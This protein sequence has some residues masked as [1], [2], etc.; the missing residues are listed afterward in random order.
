MR[1]R[2]FD[3]YLTGFD[4]ALLRWNILAYGRGVRSRFP[5]PGSRADARPSSSCYRKVSRGDVADN[6]K[7]A[8]VEMR[9]RRSRVGWSGR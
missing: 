1:G 4:C 5:D 8:V 9:C 2:A 6:M 3:A 7:V